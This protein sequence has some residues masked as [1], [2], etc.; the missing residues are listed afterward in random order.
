MNR[1]VAVVVAGLSAL[2]FAFQAQAVVFCYYL[3]NAAGSPATAIT[4][5]GYTATALTGLSAAD[6][7]A[8]DDLWIVNGNNGAPDAQV[9]GN[10]AAVAAFVNAGRTLSMHDRNV[11]QG[12]SA[13]TYLPGGSGIS[14][15]NDFGTDIDVLDTSVFG[16]SITNTNLD[17]GNYSSHGY[18]TAGSLTALGAHN[19]L[20]TG[21]A[22]H[23]VDFWYSFGAGHVYYSTIPLDFYFSGSGNDPPATTLRNVYAPREAAFQASFAA[24]AAN[25]VPEPATLALFALGLAGLGLSRRRQPT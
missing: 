7:A 6:L 25:N 17:G 20:S 24:I 1:I 16:A 5:N 15:T 13:A 23:I 19:V 9:T 14:F 4:A 2:G 10:A 21:D 18:A 8:C 11:N 22:T 3:S 12:L